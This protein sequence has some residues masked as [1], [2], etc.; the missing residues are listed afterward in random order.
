M[1]VGITKSLEVEGK[2]FPSQSQAAE[3]YG[4]DVAVFNLRINRL[5]WTPEEAAG[6]VNRDWGGKDVP[7]SVEG[8]NYSSIRQAAIAYGKDFRRIYDRYSE[9]G[10]TI[11]QALDLVNPPDTVKYQG[12]PVTVFGVT[13]PSIAQAAQAHKINSE[14]LRRRIAIGLSPDDAMTLAID[15]KRKTKDIE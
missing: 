3:F 8:I 6:L 10:W 14:S 7:I 13:Y 15:R 4:V 12:K 1:A 2:R 11:E 5:K 9:K